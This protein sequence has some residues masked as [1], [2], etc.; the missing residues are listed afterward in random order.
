MFK[1]VGLHSMIDFNMQNMQNA[2]EKNAQIWKEK[3]ENVHK[4]CRICFS[5]CNHCYDIFCIS[6]TVYTPNVADG[7]AW[8]YTELYA[9]T[10]IIP[11]FVPKLS[12][13]WVFFLVFLSTGEGRKCFRKSQ[14]YPPFENP[15]LDTLP[16]PVFHTGPT[17]VFHTILTPVFIPFLA[18]FFIPFLAPFFIPFLPPFSIP[19]YAH[20]RR[21]WQ[22]YPFFITSPHS[23]SNV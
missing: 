16:K 15:I 22:A 21:H 10:K 1:N 6:H 3:A 2:C 23:S 8:A 5:V 17:P 4:M 19:F 11:I 20:F 13:F 18:P 14:S 12:L 7:A 9:G